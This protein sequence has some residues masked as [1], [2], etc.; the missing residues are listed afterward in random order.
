MLRTTPTFGELRVSDTEQVCIVDLVAEP[1]ESLEAPQRAAIDGAEIAVD[2][3]HEI[4]VNKLTALLGRTELRDL[5]D[6]QALLD[7]G[8]DLTAALRDAPK[9]D[10]GFSPLTLAWVLQS[11]EI[12]PLARALGWSRDQAAA[13]DGF[14]RQLIDRLTRSAAP[15]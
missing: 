15:E 8:V 3:P 4:L 9:K 6:V 12:G 10:G 13:L 5:Q 1:C 7:A 14:R 11:F 2:S